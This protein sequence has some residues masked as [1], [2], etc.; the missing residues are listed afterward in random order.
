MNNEEYED[1]LDEELDEDWG[2]DEEEYIIEIEHLVTPGNEDIIAICA[3]YGISDWKSV[4]EYNKIK[5]PLSIK[6]GD[7]I[8]IQ[9]SEE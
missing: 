3:E 5:N 4:L 1:E 7:T 6:A 2:E 8:I 9:K